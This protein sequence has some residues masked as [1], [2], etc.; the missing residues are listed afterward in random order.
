[1]K[2]TNQ[3]AL[4]VVVLERLKRWS[5]AGDLVGGC[6]AITSLRQ[7]PCVVFAS[8]SHKRIIA[9]WIVSCPSLTTDLRFNVVPCKGQKERPGKC[10]CVSGLVKISSDAFFFWG[11]G[12]LG[13]FCKGNDLYNF[14][15]FKGFKIFGV[16]RDP[17]PSTWV[18]PCL[19]QLKFPKL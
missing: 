15:F 12:G 5:L 16:A 14:C 3:Y 17:H 18:R 10:A 7:G 1:M 11:G 13:N 9:L 6:S 8:G 4:L 2:L 19:Y